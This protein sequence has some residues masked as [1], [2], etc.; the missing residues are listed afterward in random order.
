[1]FSPIIGKEN[2]NLL[3]DNVDFPETL[4]VQETNV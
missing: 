3:T 1:M 4:L 2:L